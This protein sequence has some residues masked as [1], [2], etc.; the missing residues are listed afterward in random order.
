MKRWDQGNKKRTTTKVRLPGRVA[1]TRTVKLAQ[2]CDER[3]FEVALLTALIYERCPDKMTKSIKSNF[4]RASSVRTWA[5]RLGISF[6]GVD[7]YPVNPTPDFIKQFDRENPDI[8]LNIYVLSSPLP[9]RPSPPP[10]SQP[11][12][13]P[14]T[15]LH[16][17]AADASNP[18]SLIEP[19]LVSSNN[20]KEATVVNLVYWF[21]DNADNNGDGD[22]TN[23]ASTTRICYGCITN[24]SGLIKRRT[25]YHHKIVVCPYCGDK[26]FP[27]PYKA[28]S[29][30]V[31]KKHLSKCHNIN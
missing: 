7:T 2:P 26:Y 6:K 5:G 1:D 3:S 23:N 19:V 31:Y 11:L 16:E 18:E 14:E 24:F 4:C 12:S 21:V 13:L 10:S 15:P 22:S 30:S 17:D 20:T 28:G 27:K 25:T 9:S 29:N 8:H